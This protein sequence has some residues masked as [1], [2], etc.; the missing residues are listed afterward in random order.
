[1][2]D[3]VRSKNA[4]VL[5]KLVAIQGDI[6]LPGLGLSEEDTAL[7]AANVSVVFHAAATV[8]FDEAIKLSLQMNVLGTK[9]MIE[10]CHKMDKLVVSLL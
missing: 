8:K 2:F 3:N 5:K 6:M 4:D 1:M 7:L 10:L 9:R